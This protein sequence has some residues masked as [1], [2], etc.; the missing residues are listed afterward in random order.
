WLIRVIQAMYEVVS[1]AVKLDEEESDA[2]PVRVGVH[3][4]SVLSRLLFIIVLE[5]LSTEF[6]TG[7]Q[8]ELLYADD[9]VLI[10]ESEDKLLDK[11]RVWKKGFEEKG[12]KVNVGKTKVM[13]CSDE[14]SVAKEGGKFPCAI[15]SK[16]VGSNSVCYAKCKMWVHKKCS[17][18]KGR[19]K[20]DGDYQCKKC[21]VNGTTVGTES[22]KKK[23]ILLESGETIDCVEEFCYLGICLIV[24]VELEQCRA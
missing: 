17:G 4:G 14:F 7:V 6:R 3:Q 12:L 24:V 20:V 10:A 13:R 5:A 18:V 16:G 22:G 19:L 11:L 23:N 9:L 2:F 15:C 21:S 1:T 8:W